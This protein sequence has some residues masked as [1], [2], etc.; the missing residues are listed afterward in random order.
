MKSEGGVCQGEKA[1]PGRRAWGEWVNQ[2]FSPPDLTR[3]GSGGK[4]WH[5]LMF[6]KPIEVRYGC[7]KQ[8]QTS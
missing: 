7:E 8:M 3:R 6:S 2:K 1:P 5:A 4:M